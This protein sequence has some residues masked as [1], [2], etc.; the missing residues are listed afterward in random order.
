MIHMKRFAF[1]ILAL[2]ALSACSTP[3]ANDKVVA[4]YVTSWTDV[5]PDPFLLT[6]VNYA[7]GHVK[8]SFDGLK[9]DNVERLKA[10]V[11]LKEQNPKLKVVLSVGGWMSGNFSEMAADEAFRKAFCDDCAKAVAE[12]NLDGID[13][14]W[15][16]PGNGEGAGISWSPDDKGN[17]TGVTGEYRVRNVMVNG[18]PLDPEKTYTVASHNYMLK[19]GGDGYGMFKD[20][21]FL[22]DCV[23]IDNQVLINYIVEK[24]NGTVGEDYADIWG[25]GRITIING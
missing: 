11:K 6:H 17:F 12:L 14:D 8:D 23:M 20:N 2:C 15:E 13:I 25:Q 19:S 7:F 22:L 21:N 1:L 18:E 10:I 16:Y 24:L 9:I 5:M 3:V 4:S